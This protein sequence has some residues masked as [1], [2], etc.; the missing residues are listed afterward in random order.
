MYLHNAQFVVRH[1]LIGLAIGAQ[2]SNISAARRIQGI[3]SID[4]DDDTSTFQIRGEVRI[5]GFY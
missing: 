2:G 5:Y 3:S 1:D 4:L